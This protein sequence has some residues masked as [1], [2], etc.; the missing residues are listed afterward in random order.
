MQAALTS[1]NEHNVPVDGSIIFRTEILP[2]IENAISNLKVVDGFGPKMIQSV[3]SPTSATWRNLLDKVSNLI[4]TAR[5]SRTNPSM[6]LPVRAR[7]QSAIV[8][9]VG[10]ADDSSA[11]AQQCVL[12]QQF[13]F[14]H[15]VITHYMYDAG[16]DVFAPVHSAVDRKSSVKL[17]KGN[18]KGLIAAE[19]ASTEGKV[20]C[21]VLYMDPPWN[22]HPQRRED[23]RVFTPEEVRFSKKTSV[24]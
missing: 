18:Y 16:E 21:G 19:S 24:I 9:M 3:C 4:T 22:I 6:R 15:K 13:T 1:T 8:R 20:D 5:N 11:G 17:Y 14:E 12:N 7:P 10:A 2:D 23:S